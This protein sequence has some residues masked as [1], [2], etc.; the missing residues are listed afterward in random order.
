M[1]VTQQTDVW[2]TNK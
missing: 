2:N 1:G